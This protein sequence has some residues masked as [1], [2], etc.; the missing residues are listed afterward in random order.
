M[1]LCDIRVSKDEI[2]DI[3]GRK[4]AEKELKEMKL[5]KE[6]GDIDIRNVLKEYQDS[7]YYIL[8]LLDVLYEK[9][10]KE[11][12]TNIFGLFLDRLIKNHLLVEYFEKND[13]KLDDEIWDYEE[14]IVTKYAREW[15]EEDGWTEKKIKE[16][17]E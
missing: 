4:E 13:I 10:K 3:V 11:D 6:N 12:D 5:L 7:H 14:K 16:M 15:Y 9:H 17:K 8:A 1:K 2:L